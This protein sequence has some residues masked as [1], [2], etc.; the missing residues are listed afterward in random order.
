MHSGIALLGTR[1]YSELLAVAWDPL[2]IV[3]CDDYRI[4]DLNPAACRL[5]GLPREQLIGTSFAT[6]FSETRYLDE[7]VSLHR[8]YVPLRYQRGRGERHFPVELAI[9]YFHGEDGAEYAAIAL[10]DISERIERERI[11]NESERKYQSLFEASPYPILILNMQG[12]IVDA[13]R[14]AQGCYGLEHEALVRMGWEQLEPTASPLLFVS[15][16]TM[17]GARQHRRSDGS[18]FMAEVMLSYFRLRSQSLILAL[19]RDITEHWRTF[20]QLQESEARWRFAIEGAGDAMIDWPLQRDGSHFVSPIL[21]SMLGYDPEADEGLDADGWMDRVHADDRE[22]LTVRLQAHLRG[23]EPI[24]QVE[25]RMLECAGGE[26][27]MALRA[28]VIQRGGEPVGRLIGAIRDIHRSRMRQLRE[29]TQRERIFRLERMATA[30]E[31]LSALAH[32]VNQP[33]TAIS[34]YSSLVV[35]QFARD[36]GDES[37]ARSL[38]VISEQAL[39]AGEIVRRIRDFV[40]RAD[41]CFC[42][43]DLNSLIVRVA[44]WCENDA[45]NAG[46]QIVCDLA[47]DLPE[48][49][50]DILQIE[51]V[52][53]NLLR[54]GIEA[55]H[56]EKLSRPRRL[57]IS[58]LWD[59][60]ALQVKV[61]DHGEGIDEAVAVAMFEPFVSSKPEGMGVGL[62]IC[63]TVI[64]GHG[65][66]IWAES[67]V[68]ERG[69]CFNF[70]LQ[71][72][73]GRSR[74]VEGV[75]AGC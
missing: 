28:K 31:M 1:P 44:G 4:V 36:P 66:Q 27:W 40:R 56:D 63:R 38:R 25:F 17:L 70:T 62:A 5:Y 61:R 43:A 67:P 72:N 68:G 73:V 23:S 48:I 51:Q 29:A 30:G 39:R 19:V 16:P 22:M 2:L 53:F 35:R 55:M 52:L 41:P 6:R 26:R 42:L 65:G 12:M 11:D 49:E 32:E 7:I 57:L 60:E 18:L 21:S 69:T 20:Q 45:S 54:N 3:A 24:L 47:P 59:G 75:N 71:A 74:K 8:D 9:R 14:C 10:R 15:R 37:I 33:L 50:L 34:N 58:S 13:N 46:I 64:E